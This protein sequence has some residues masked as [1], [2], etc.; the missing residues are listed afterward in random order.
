MA[1]KYGHAAV[2]GAICSFWGVAGVVFLHSVLLKRSL[3]ILVATAI[4]ITHFF[5][6]M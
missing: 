1:D 2:M 3:G 5:I 6:L 4:F